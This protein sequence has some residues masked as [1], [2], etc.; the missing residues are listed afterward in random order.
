MFKLSKIFFIFD[1]FGFLIPKILIKF[2][3]NDAKN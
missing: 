3:V 2:D 1:V